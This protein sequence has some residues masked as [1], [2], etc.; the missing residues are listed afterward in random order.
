MRNWRRIIAATGAAALAAGAVTLPADPAGHMVT[1]VAGCVGFAVLLWRWPRSRG[2]VAAITTGVGV[3]SIAVTMAVSGDGRAASAAV[4]TTLWMMLEPAVLA[5]LAYLTLRWSTPRVALAA[6]GTAAVG[7]ALQVQRYL[8]FDPLWERAAA[9]L[10]WLFPAMLAAGAGWY[11]REM[12]E[13]RRAAVA[14]ARQAQRLD[15]AADLHDFVAHD[16]SEIVAQAQAARQVL[17]P[18]QAMLAVLERIEAAGLRALSSMDRTVGVLRQPGDAATRP[19]GGM[20]DIPEIVARFSQAGG[21]TARLQPE[22]MPDAPR[23]VAAVAHRIVVEALTNVRRHAPE[24]DTVTVE[25]TDESSALSVTVTDAG[26]GRSDGGGRAS[27]FGLAGLTQRVEAIG[28]TLTAGP[29]GDG[30]RLAATLPL[31]GM[32]RGDT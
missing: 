12:A 19:T 28:G 15:L 11:L 3:V 23:E 13:R 25:L 17:S 14:E 5:V 32:R 8:W 16:V 6:A 27:G 20:A 22:Q 4:P 30:W 7:T 2:W 24:A 1:P 29:Q 10:L 9:S 31:T 18:D 21:T 26:G